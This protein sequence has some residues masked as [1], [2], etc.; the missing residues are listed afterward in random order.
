M[1]GALDLTSCLRNLHLAPRESN[2]FAVES[3]IAQAMSVC[4]LELLL[5]SSPRVCGKFLVVTLVH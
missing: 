4:H 3:R 5:G 1:P 2:L